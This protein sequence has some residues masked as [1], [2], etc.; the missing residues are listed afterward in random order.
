MN[1][2]WARRAILI[3][4]VRPRACRNV[5]NNFIFTGRLVLGIPTRQV[6]PASHF[7]EAQLCE[8][9]PYCDLDF[10]RFGWPLLAKNVDCCDKFGGVGYWL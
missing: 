5:Q 8:E 7:N 3:R 6:S 9:R 2:W 4:A 10:G 1:E